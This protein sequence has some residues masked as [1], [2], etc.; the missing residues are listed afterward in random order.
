MQVSGVRFQLSGDRVKKDSGDLR[1]PNLTPDTRPR[2]PGSSDT[3]PLTPVLRGFQPEDFEALYRLDQLCF[4]EEIAYSRDD[5]AGFLSIPSAEGV[6]A[7]RDGEIAGFSLGYLSRSRVAHI[8][9]LD[10]HPESRREGLGRALLEELL[11][12]FSRS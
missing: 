7:E 4:E 5:L 12:R 10:V 8:V 6:V 9:T 3:L 1:H 11:E 2:T